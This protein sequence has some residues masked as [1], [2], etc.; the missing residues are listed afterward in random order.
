[1][2]FRISEDFISVLVVVDSF[3]SLGE[4]VLDEWSPLTKKCS[5]A[6]SGKV[7]EDNA[8]SCRCFYIY[9]LNYSF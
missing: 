3:S 9:V 1:M 4:L 5:K 8:F 6:G 7:Q 2:D